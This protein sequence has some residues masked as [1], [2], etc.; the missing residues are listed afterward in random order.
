MPSEKGFAGGNLVGRSKLRV[1]V[2]NAQAELD[3]I[4][5]NLQQGEPREAFPEKFTVEARTILESQI[6]N[7]KKTL[8]AL[9]AA[10]LLLLLIAC[11]NVAN[12]LLVR[13][14]LR[15][16]EFAMRVTLG[17]TRGRLIRQLLAESFILS[18]TASAVGWRARVFRTEGC[19][20][21][22]PS[23]HTARSDGHSHEYACP[24][25]DARRYVS[26]HGFMRI[27]TSSACSATGCAASPYRLWKM[28][29][30][31]N[32]GDFVEFL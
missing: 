6:G 19:C 20:R 30:G 31:S 7:F 32:R 15:E 8:Y 14:T 9:L 23:Q 2:E 4:A 11:S 1:S 13:A 22:D 16:R 24:A 17:A 21:A 27:R 12:L 3:A 29:E 28:V 18:G 26:E 25:P 5:H 10:V